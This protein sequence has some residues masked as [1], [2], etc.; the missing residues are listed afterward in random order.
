[1]VTQLDRNPAGLNG[2]Q[3]KVARL[4]VPFVAP[5]GAPPCAR[6]QLRGNIP[7]EPAD[8][9]TNWLSLTLTRPIRLAPTGLGPPARARHHGAA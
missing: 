2:K 9:A 5:V 8:S 3:Q 7:P 4:R 1:M 6:V